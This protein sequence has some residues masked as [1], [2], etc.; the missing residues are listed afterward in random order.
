[1]TI[2]RGRNPRNVRCEPSQFYFKPR[3][4]PLIDIPG[5]EEITI[6]ELEAIRLTDLEGMKQQEAAEKMKISQST[7]SRHLEAAHRKI[8]NALLHG[9]AIKI[10]NPTDYY[11]CEECGH[12]Q[13]V[14][15]GGL[16]QELEQCEQCHST[17]IHLHVHSNYEHRIQSLK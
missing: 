8:A 9:L 10:A 5:E 3:G 14:P 4:V 1:M 16:E 11:H 13:L 7:I 6:E 12:I 17:K 15:E 2:P